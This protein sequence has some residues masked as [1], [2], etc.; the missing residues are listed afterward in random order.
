MGRTL[1]TIVVAIALLVGLALFDHGREREPAGDALA[2]R[3]AGAQESGE[4]TTSPAG[5]GLDSSLTDCLGSLAAKPPARSEFPGLDQ[6]GVEE[7]SD[8]VER[9]R[10]LTFSGPVDATFLGN[11]AL[12]R[13]IDELAGTKGSRELAARQGAALELLGAI[14]EGSDLYEL[15]T[16]ALAAQVVGLYVPETKQLL[17]ATSGDPGAVEE[18]TLAHEL[19]HA[20]ADDDLGL[21]STGKVAAGEGDRDLAAQSLVE[22]DATLT[23]ELY[24]LRY[25]DLSDQLDLGEDP[26][27]A[28][29]G[30]GK[31]PD[32]LRRQLLFPYEAGLQYVCDRFEQGGWQAVDDAYRDPPASTAELL[33]LRDADPVEAPPAGRL[34][35]PWRPVLRDQLGAAALAWL[36]AAPGGDPDRALPDPREPIGGWAG[37]KVALWERPGGETALSLSIVDEGGSLCGAMIAWYAATNPEAELSREGD[38]TSFSDEAA[39]RAAAVS[40]SGETVLVGIGP[41]QETAATLAAEGS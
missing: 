29:A 36:F 25:V 35:A 33:G 32:F 31:L 34:D 23:M 16:R 12:D 19:E 18:I 6:R 2:G 17:V 1:A 4:V 28:D 10:E 22:G 5:G 14:P 20:L 39:G 37:D 11:A 3:F 38:T 7:I 13:R 26:Q 40:C 30:L 41:D 24:A 9:I 8:R 21:P 15:T 27:V